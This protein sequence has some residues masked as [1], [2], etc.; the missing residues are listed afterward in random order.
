MTEQDKPET[1]TGERRVRTRW[2]DMIAANP[3]HSD[4]YIQRF[5]QMAAQGADLAGEARMVDAMVGRGARILDAGCGPG[6]VG[7]E[8][9][10]RGHSVVGVD[11]D[12]ALIA[13]ASRVT[14]EGVDAT[15]LTGDIAELDLPEW[16]G[17][18]G[19]DVIVCAGNV[20]T[21]LAPGTERD[22][23]AAFAWHLAPGGRAVIGFGAGRGYEFAD[24]LSDA[25]ASGLSP[26]LLLSTWD[27]QP[28]TLGN[29]DFLVAV[30]SAS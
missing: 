25:A 2:E 1:S 3:A 20:M 6:R 28:F 18:N 21:F 11:V 23:L 16:R 7:L 19:F 4:W 12:P 27:L 26:S 14:P 29:S 13:E 10:S 15:W 8:L 9:A 22:V 5:A 30:L 17:E 24:F